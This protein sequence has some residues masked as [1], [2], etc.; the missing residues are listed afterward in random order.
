M[1]FPSAPGKAMDAE[2]ESRPVLTI[3]LHF[4]DRQ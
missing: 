1:Q 3:V 4:E 2:T